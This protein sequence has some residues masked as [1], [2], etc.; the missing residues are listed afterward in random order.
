MT[1]AW[2]KYNKHRVIQYTL[3]VAHNDSCDRIKVLDAYSYLLQIS[4][5]LESKKIVP[6][7]IHFGV[8]RASLI[9]DCNHICCADIKSW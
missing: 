1:V 5:R 6:L 2:L 3:V 9:F 7:Y 4:R 8:Y